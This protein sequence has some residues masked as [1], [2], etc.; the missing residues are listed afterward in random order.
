MQNSFFKCLFCNDTQADIEPSRWV[1]HNCGNNYPLIHGIPVLVRDWNAHQLELDN[2]SLIKPDWYKTIQDP[3]DVSPWRHNHRKRRIFVESRIRDWLNDKKNEK[4]DN[5]LDLGCGDGNHLSYLKKYG[6]SI[7]GSDYNM[8]RLVRSILRFPEGTFFLADLLDYP[9][10][11]NFFDLIF[12]NH[13]IEHIANDDLA[14]KNVFCALKPGGLLIL[15]TPNEGARWWQFAYAIQPSIRRQTDHVQ[16]YTAD[17]LSGKME[18]A[19]FK[20]IEIKHIGWGP[21]HFTLD[22]KIRRYQFIDDA[23]EFLGKKLFPSQ[24]TSLYVLATKE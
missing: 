6:R 17:S 8:V 2:L 5:L 1:C 4:V 12:F 16:F 19:G 23:F 21:P 15:G 13:V 10:R 7:F 9:S 11:E 3:E 14:L 24:A 18:R 20:I 22:S